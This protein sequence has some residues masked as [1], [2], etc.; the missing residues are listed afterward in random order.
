MLRAL[1]LA[2]ALAACSDRAPPPPSG[3]AEDLAAYLQRLAATDRDT[4]RREVAAW[5]LDR[6][7]WDR[8]VVA[9]FR[10]RYVA[11]VSHFELRFAGELLPHA[12][13]IAARRH[14]A[15]D[16]R[17]TVGQAILRWVL[18]VQYP[19]LVA[20]LDG[21]PIDTVFVHD[22]VR[23]RALT[24]FDQELIEYVEQYAE[25]IQPLDTG[26]QR[27]PAPACLATMLGVHRASACASLWFEATDAALRNDRPR[28]DRMCRLSTSLCDMR[29]P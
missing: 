2:L 29:S 28:F 4:Q 15:G 12:G 26:D 3:S 14:Y 6:A 10:G 21:A 18:P 25:G 22:G 17:L 5:K 8:T 24:G 1:A 9:P 13:T 27:W 7:T 19:S 23:W 20:E 11:Y 16:P